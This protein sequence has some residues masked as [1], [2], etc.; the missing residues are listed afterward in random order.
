MKCLH[1][2]SRAVDNSNSNING[3]NE[4]KK[5]KFAHDTMNLVEE[6]QEK[7]KQKQEIPI[8]ISSVSQIS[9][10]NY[11]DCTTEYKKNMVDA[12]TNYILSLISTNSL[13]RSNRITNILPINGNLEK[14]IAYLVNP[15]TRQNLCTVC[16][17]SIK[18]SRLIEIIEKDVY[19][20]VYK[21]KDI[22]QELIGFIEG[23]PDRKICA[24]CL[25]IKYSMKII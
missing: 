3:F 22:C 7:Q 4:T 17:D 12:M 19:Y 11:I 5:R 13:Y 9:P 16:D 18:Q 23:V 25:I 21:Y 24:M 1:S 20:H 2:E 14:C 15:N 6:K 10:T 8:A